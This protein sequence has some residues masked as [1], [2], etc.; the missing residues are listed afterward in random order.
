MKLN[1]LRRSHQWL[2]QTVYFLA[3]VLTN[4]ELAEIDKQLNEKNDSHWS[5]VPTALAMWLC[6]IGWLSWDEDLTDNIKRFRKR[7]A[8]QLVGVHPTRFGHNSKPLK[9]IFKLKW[10]IS[11]RLSIGLKSNRVVAERQK[12]A[13]RFSYLWMNQTKSIKSEIW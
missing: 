10:S 5:F 1:F 6:F 9:Y 4:I 2:N 7:L 3:P 13:E 11:P 8:F 12:G